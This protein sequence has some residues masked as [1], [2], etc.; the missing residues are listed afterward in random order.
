MTWTETF[1]ITVRI[2]L[3]SLNL[4]L[5]GHSNEDSDQCSS[6]HV[7]TCAREESS[8]E[9]QSGTEV[10]S[11]AFVEE[12]PHK[13]VRGLGERGSEE[14]DRG[15]TTPLSMPSVLLEV[16]HGQDGT[17]SQSHPQG[18]ESSRESS[19]VQGWLELGKVLVRVHICP[20]LETQLELVKAKGGLLTLRHLRD[21]GSFCWGQDICAL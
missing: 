19:Q 6:Q 4:H 18:R 21:N 16:D 17:A 11:T 10:L 15:G 14:M 1:K 5:S 3:S 7:S 8:A 20:Q 2:N 13:P 9:V 12:E